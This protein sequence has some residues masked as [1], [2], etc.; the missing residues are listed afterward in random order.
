MVQA[1]FPFEESNV[2]DCQ[3]FFLIVPGN[4]DPL[5]GMHGEEKGFDK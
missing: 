2:A 3:K 1:L 5:T 4:F